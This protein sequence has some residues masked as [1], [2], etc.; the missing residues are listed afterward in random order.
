MRRLGDDQTCH[1]LGDGKKI[2]VCHLDGNKRQVEEQE[3]GNRDN[4]ASLLDCELK[5]YRHRC[6][7]LFEKL[8]IS[9]QQYIVGSF[10]QANHF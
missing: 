1:L 4:F 3:D 7:I 9:I 5:L 2:H 6:Q 8:V 10:L